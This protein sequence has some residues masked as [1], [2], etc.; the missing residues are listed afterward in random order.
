MVSAMRALG[1]S[2]GPS[3][4][5]AL[6]LA[7]AIS[8]ARDQQWVAY[9]IDRFVGPLISYDEDRHTRLYEIA[10]H[11]FENGG[12]LARTAAVLH[13]ADDGLDFR[14]PRGLLRI[15]ETLRIPV[16]AFGPFPNAARSPCLDRPSRPTL[17]APRRR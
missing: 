13:A 3:D 8:G 16:F 15:T 14:S 10:W 11:Y 6:G 2:H 9:L 1:R 12:H 7:G 5:I 4:V 17:L